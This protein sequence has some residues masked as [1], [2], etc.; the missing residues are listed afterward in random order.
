MA[1]SFLCWFQKLD[2]SFWETTF[3]ISRQ[4]VGRCWSILFPF[5]SQFGVGET[6]RFWKQMPGKTFLVVELFSKSTFF[7]HKGSLMKIQRKL[8]LDCGWPYNHRFCEASCVD[9]IF[10][11]AMMSQ[12]YVGDECERSKPL[13]QNPQVQSYHS[14]FTC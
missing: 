12:S 1:F 9:G 6:A 4:I 11:F 3:P 8:A 2:S 14:L 7:Q 10:D 13:F 5:P